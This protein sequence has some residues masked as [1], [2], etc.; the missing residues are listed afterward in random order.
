MS[1]VT[2]SGSRVGLALGY[3]VC[4]LARTCRPGQ[5][6]RRMRRLFDNAGSVCPGQGLVPRKVC[7]HSLNYAWHPGFSS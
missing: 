1:I 6:A 4:E 3:A 5:S 7:L 2:A